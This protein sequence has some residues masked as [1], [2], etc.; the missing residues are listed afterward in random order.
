MEGVNLFMVKRRLIALV[1]LASQV[2]SPCRANDL[3]TLKVN[4]GGLYSAVDFFRLK[5]VC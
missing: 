2:R 1:C 5:V 4:G 3:E